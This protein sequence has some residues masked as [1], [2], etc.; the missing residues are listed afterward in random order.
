[1]EGHGNFFGIYI[2]TLFCMNKLLPLIFLCILFSGYS[3]SGGEYRS[4]PLESFA[5]GEVL[6]YRVHYGFMTAGEAVMVVDK[7]IHNL[8]KRPCYKIDVFGRT[9][10]MAD[11][12]F[13]VEDNWGTFLDTAAVLPHRS[14]RFIKEGRYRKNE[15]VQFD[16][17]ARK[18]LVKK[19]KKDSKKVEEVKSYEVPQN[20]QDIVS[21][22][23]FLRTMDYSKVK[24]G[25]ILS[26]DA[27]FDEEV[28]DF[29]V[30]FVGREEIKT[31]LGKK[32]AIVL[33][34]LLPEN[35]L[36]EGKDPIQV[37]LSDDKHRIPLKIRANMFVGALE[38]DIKEYQS[39]AH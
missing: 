20:V 25:E 22:Y 29:N 36:F 16:Q 3:P 28:F 19:L 17:L 33:Q 26:I 23:Y 37:W 9:T 7:E 15:I 30:R 6:K 14:Y 32:Q 11:N 2:D 31:K 12:L 4:I 8:N 38:I 21:G 13:G 39:G 34:P 18:A 10:G 35:S 24:K 1:M 5:Q 27:F